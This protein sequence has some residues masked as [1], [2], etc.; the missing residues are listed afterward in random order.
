MIHKVAQERTMLSLT[1]VLRVDS[2][3]FYPSPHHLSISTCMSAVT[4]NLTCF[5]KIWVQKDDNIA[6]VL[7]KSKALR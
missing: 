5:F 7:A 1:V 3:F 6:M 2:L 4:I